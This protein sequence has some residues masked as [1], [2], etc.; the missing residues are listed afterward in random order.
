MIIEKTVKYAKETGEVLDLAIEVVKVIK[1]GG[2]YQ[3]LVDEL[4]TAITGIEDIPAE[5]KDIE[6][7][8]NTITPKIYEFIKAFVPESK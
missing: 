4:V 2:D 8:V 3:S 1:N 6:A 5:S 7:M